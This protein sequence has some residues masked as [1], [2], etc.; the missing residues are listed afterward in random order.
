[1]DHGFQ[2]DGNQ[3]GDL[4]PEDGAVA[5]LLRLLGEKNTFLHQVD[6]LCK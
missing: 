5:L 6:A 1:M 4:L 3:T 2:E